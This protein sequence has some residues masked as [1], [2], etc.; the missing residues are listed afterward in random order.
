MTLL[1]DE[2]VPRQLG[3]FFPE[4][5]EVF[6]VQKMGWTGRG[7]GDLLR[8]AAV[9]GFDAFITADQGIE[10]QQNVDRLPIPVLV[11]VAPRTRVKELRPLVPRV[12]DVVTGPLRRRIYRIAE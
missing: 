1:L 9:R 4:A 2:S 11:L 5:F 6:T 7:N 8:L 12:V 10:H 3:R